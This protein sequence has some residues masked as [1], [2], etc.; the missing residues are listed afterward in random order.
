MFWNY[1]MFDYKYM[2]L[3]SKITFTPILSDFDYDFL[4]NFIDWGL[5]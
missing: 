5:W 2:R 4:N 1:F 3:F